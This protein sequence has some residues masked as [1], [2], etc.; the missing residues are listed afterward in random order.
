MQVSS[1]LLQLLSQAAYL[2]CFRGDSKHSQIIMD[3][4]N[5]VGREQ[6]P[7]KMGLAIIKVYAG[8]YKQ[9]ITILRDQI[10]LEDPNHM[11]AKCFLGMAL[12]QVGEKAASR[13]MLE[14]VVI[15]GSKDERDLASAY[16][17]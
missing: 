11:T 16:L 6:I 17:T 5:A 4:V 14:E 3:G 12:K 7:I 8:Q 1:E 10:L 13:E 9:A 2:A 15:K